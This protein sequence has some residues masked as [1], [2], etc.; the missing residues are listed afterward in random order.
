MMKTLGFLTVT[1]PDFSMTNWRPWADMGEKLVR[2]STIVV[3]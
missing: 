3:K 2:I 1:V